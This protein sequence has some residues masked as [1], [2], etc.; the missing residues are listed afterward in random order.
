MPRKFTITTPAETV[1][2]DAGGRGEMVFTVTNTTSEPQRALLRATPVGATQAEWLSIAGDAER[3]FAAGGMQ[4]FSVAA[5][6]PPGTAAGRYTY[7]LDVLA[8]S[9]AGEDREEGPTVAFEVAATEPPKK[10]SRAWLWIVLLVLLLIAAVVAFLLLRKGGD[11]KVVVEPEAP[12]SLR[13]EVPRSGIA[14][15]LVADEAQPTP[16]SSKVDVWQSGE[17]VTVRASAVS[18]A[19]QPE[20]VPDAING[21]AVLRF[22]G[23]DDMLI[24]N[25]AFGR[26]KMPA[27]TVFTVFSSATDA[28]SPYRKLYGCDD[29]GFDPAVG[30]D[31]RSADANYVVFTGNGVHPYFQLRANS[32]TLTTDHYQWTQ[33]T[34][35]VDGKLSVDGVPTAHDTQT[36]PHLYIGGT[37]SVFREPWQG[38]I[39]EMIVYA[40]NLDDAERRKVED[41]L[42][43]K[44]RLTLSR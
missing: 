29:G 21:H 32:V 12:A 33:F 2:V 44:Y 19:G 1:R 42:A 10:A 9:R 3:A 20:L 7:R 15:W 26:G 37:G 4:Q 31:N 36:L 17:L 27:A 22:D 34:G 18:I 28:T 25:V 40:R 24:T 14:L 30:L 13:A 43:D 16:G 38:D 35:W 23:I 41:Y 8:A 11:D 39:A 5:H 6:I